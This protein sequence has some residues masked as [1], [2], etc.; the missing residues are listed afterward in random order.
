ML[1][2]LEHRVCGNK[3]TLSSPDGLQVKRP[4]PFSI[5]SQTASCP[6]W[7][8]LNEFSH[9]RSDEL[10]CRCEGWNLVA[11]RFLLRVKGL[12]AVPPGL[13]GQPTRFILRLCLRQL[14]THFFSDLVPG[15]AGA[16]AADPCFLCRERNQT[17]RQGN[18]RRKCGWV[19]VLAMTWVFNY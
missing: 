5:L 15:D 1:L 11:N 9:W 6:N 13:L 14:G 12:F 16:G 17:Q 4:S 10:P 3:I 19:F 8:N 18:E 7:N 2:F